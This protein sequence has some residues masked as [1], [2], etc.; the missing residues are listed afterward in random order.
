MNVK[1]VNISVGVQ[2]KQI[3]KHAGIRYLKSHSAVVATVVVV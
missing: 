1:S 3:I 2:V